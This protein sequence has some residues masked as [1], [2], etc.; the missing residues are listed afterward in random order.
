L[1]ESTGDLRIKEDE[2][3]ISSGVE[4]ERRDSP[5]DFGNIAGFEGLIKNLITIV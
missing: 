3:R 1:Q 2:L 4:K 5:D